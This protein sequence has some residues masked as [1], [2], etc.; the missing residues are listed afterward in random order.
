M[1]GLQQKLVQLEADYH[2]LL[3]CYREIAAGR[4]E[5][6]SWMKNNDMEALLDYLKE[7]EAIMD[8]A[9]LYRRQIQET[10]ALIAAENNLEYFSIPSLKE[11]LFPTLVEQLDRIGELINT[12]IE[13]LTTLEVQEK[14]LEQILRQRTGIISGEVN[15]SQKQKIAKK[16]YSNVPKLPKK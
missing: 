10:Q 14:Q 8:Q 2:N 9:E 6:I 15:K 16:A 11:K 12:L 1:T 13:E 7:K 5:E 3:K 4:E